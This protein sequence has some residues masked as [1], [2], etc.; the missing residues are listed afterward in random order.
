MNCILGTQDVL[1]NDSFIAFIDCII[2]G[3]IQMN[4][5]ITVNFIFVTNVTDHVPSNLY[6]LS[7]LTLNV[8]NFIEFLKNQIDSDKSE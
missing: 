7:K 2:T 3:C 4:L 8:Q 6:E 5:P 1:V